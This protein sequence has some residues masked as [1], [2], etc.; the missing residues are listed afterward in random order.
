[1]QPLIGITSANFVQNG[2]LYNRVYAPNA[3]AIAR[4]GGL[5]VF[6]P[7]GLDEVTLRALYERLDA[8]LLPGGPDIDPSYY[9]AVRHPLTVEVDDLR[10]QLELTIT[11]WAVQ[12][13]LPVFGICRGHQVLNVALGGTL[14]QDISAELGSTLPHDIPA[15][16]PRSTLVH[17][18]KI[19]DESHL[20]SILGA[21]SVHVNSLHHQSVEKPAP[22]IL[23]SAYASDGVI[24]ALES[25]DHH[26]VLSVQ[27]HPEDLYES[28]E[29]MMRL[30]TAF[31]QAARE[32]AVLRERT[33]P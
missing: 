6:I 11:R 20:A 24:E 12:D 29:A 15:D 28:D 23:V 21:T 10:D 32:R 22:G 16:T 25:P 2:K 18:V 17:D 1:L 14:V 33:A 3:K 26:F 7:T 31:V 13:D 30:F 8:V 9:D 19:D 4:A 5:P 27:W